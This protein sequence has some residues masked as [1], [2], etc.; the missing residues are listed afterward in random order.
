MQIFTVG[1]MLRDAATKYPDRTALV[2]GS[3]PLEQRRRISYAGLL[4]RAE[5]AARALVARYPAGTHIAVWSPNTVEWVILQ[6]AAALAGMPLVLLNPNLRRPEV[7]YI[8]EHSQSKA[9]FA[10]R[11]FRDS[12]MMEIV[13]SLQSEL[14]DLRDIFLLESL[15]DLPTA[16]VALPEVTPQDCAL[17][18]YTSGTTGKPK[19]VLL[20]HR[21]ITEIGTLGARPMRLPDPARW[22]LILPLAS[23]GGSVYAVMGALCDAATLVVAG[24]F[25]AG[26]MVRLIDEEKISFFNA[27]TTIHIRMLEHPAMA[28]A[29]L[30]SLKGVTIGGSTVSPSLIEQIE[31]DYDAECFTTYGMTET[32]GT[33]ALI[34]PGD[35]IQK[36]AYT[37]GRPIIGVEVE[38]RDIATGQAL[39]AEAEGEICVRSIGNLMGYFRAPEETAKAIDNEGWLRTGDIGALDQD[40]FLKI[41]GR[42]KELIKRGG[43]NVYPREIED[44][45]VCHEAVA[46]C[47]IFGV[48]HR[49]LGEEIAAAVRLVSEGSVD[50]DT[51]RSWLF[52]QIAPHKIPR[53]WF[54]V[55]SFP[56]NANGKVQ[57]FELRRIYSA[58]PA[59]G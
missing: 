22:L 30:E 8:L 10:A 31:A 47:A 51:L 36:K 21:G 41:T 17:M 1:S 28:E 16:D 34:S 26:R 18:L 32:S 29:S 56:T 35:S 58:E 33:V 23:V 43:H 57:K 37:A 5:S 46:E 44:V 49:E 20:A 15:K 14:P 27:A 6:M 2:D 55:E 3:V 25:D 54:F 50:G 7:Q 39:P 48:P 4:Q 45:L 19:G 11:R 13:Q 12:D 40:G 38:I 42:L 52:Q 24:E 53:L 59:A 9:V